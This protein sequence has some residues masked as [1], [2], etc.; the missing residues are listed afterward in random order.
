M[1]RLCTD[2][3]SKSFE[4]KK[5][6]D[7]V[8][9]CMNSGSIHALLGENGAGKSTL[10][11]IISGSQIPSTGSLSLG[12]VPFMTNTISVKPVQFSSPQHA[13]EY[14]I[15]MVHQRPLIA[16]SLTVLENCTLGIEKSFGAKSRLL[17]IQE[18]WN[19]S[20]PLTKKA[21]FLNA[22]QIFYAELLCALHKKPRLLILDEP[23]SLLDEVQRKKLFS[24]L[25]THVQDGLSVLLITHNINDAINYSSHI[26]VLKKGRIILS[27][28]N[29][30]N[31]PVKFEYINTALF[32]SKK[33]TIQVKEK[34]YSKKKHVAEEKGKALIKTTQISCKE[35]NRTSLFSVSFSVYESAIT[36]IQGQR[37][38]GIETLEEILTGMEHISFFGS[39]TFDEK[40][41]TAKHPL[42]PKILRKK[43][44][45]IIP[46]NKTF[47]ASH[48]ELSI[49]ELLTV[50]GDPKNTKEEEE[51]FSRTLIENEMLNIDI[52]EPVK[53]LSGGMLQRL[54]LEREISTDPS[55]LL[56]FEP[57]LGLDSLALTSLSK[58]I[59]ALADTGCGVL[60][61]TSVSDPKIFSIADYTYHMNGGK[62][63]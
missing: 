4:H 57:A 60:I 25:L 14:G 23:T 3:I 2:N 24:S 15:V 30:K 26:T 59:R 52:D 9:L 8:S 31:K 50:Y 45:A 44:G 22:S 41:Y 12:A 29:S 6:L 1:F 5:A 49:L 55:L 54:I 58:N 53:N 19:I 16:S 37:E 20:V 56:L 27:E 34:P 18:E 21:Q 61:L 32:D 40:K 43:G 10:A 51:S 39:I 28:A 48:P 63:V 35:K 11:S 47:R 7:N 13:Q 46:S 17:K 33:N 38:S 62:L 42:T 36:L